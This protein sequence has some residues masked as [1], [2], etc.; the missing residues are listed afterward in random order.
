M[1]NNEE[2]EGQRSEESNPCSGTHDK[3]IA[4]ATTQE[5]EG[6]FPSIHEP[7]GIFREDI[8]VN[9]VKKEPVTQDSHMTN[10]AYS[11]QIG[12]VEIV[13]ATEDFIKIVEDIDQVTLSCS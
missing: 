11:Y 8:E 13:P 3:E 10:A 1:I 12:D 6:P 5:A 2:I 4:A 9:E 7:T